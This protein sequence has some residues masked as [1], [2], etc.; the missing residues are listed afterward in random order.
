MTRLDR[1]YSPPEIGAPGKRSA[2]ER[3]RDL[4][5]TGLFVLAMAALAVAALAV[6]SPGLFAGAYRLHS[7][8][9]D[10]NGLD[11]GIPV[12]QDG[13]TIGMVESVTPIFP[14]RD[15]EAVRCPAAPPDRP[16]A[17]DLP[18]FRATLRILDDWPVPVGSVAELGAAG[19]LQG[20]AIRVLPGTAAAT[21]E[22]GDVL[23]A[24]GRPPDLL[25][26]LGALTGTL[27]SIVDQTIAPALA[28]IQAQIETIGK[29]I[30][31]E[32]GDGA[33]GAGAV[34]RERLAGAFESLQRITADIEK[35]IDPEQ[36]GSILGA[37][38]QLT[39]NLATVSGTFT[40][41]SADLRTAVQ[42]YSALAGDLR[43]VISA[44]EPGLSSSVDNLQYLLQELSAS[45]API[46]ANIE[47]ASR[48]LSALSR[49][50]REHPA[51]L[52]RGHQQEEQA[53]WFQKR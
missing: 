32:D 34:G 49:E 38:Q 36:I 7:Y 4:F 46:L 40:E 39:D 14:G 17:P 6:V 25:A 24:R 26:Q 48:N 41:R 18:C 10:A 20:D 44:N 1:L 5:L 53:P 47:N 11:R 29:L 31:T 13:Y 12:L 51:A 37:V 22:A 15:A 50:L 19:L 28:S 42:D 2:Q 30:G 8:F 9:A 43:R 21:L 23:P 16:R 45:L 27:Q 3:H 52:L 33:D 35:V